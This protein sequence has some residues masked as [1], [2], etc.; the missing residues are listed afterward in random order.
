MSFMWWLVGIIFMLFFLIEDSVEI[1][2]R[3]LNI[4]STGSTFEV[5]YD[6]NVYPLKV[7]DGNGDYT[8]EPTF[9][10]M[11]LIVLSIAFIMIGILI[12]RT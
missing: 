6:S 7:Q 1:D 12:E 3:V 11:M 5:N 4:T 8:L 9:G 10:G 2:D